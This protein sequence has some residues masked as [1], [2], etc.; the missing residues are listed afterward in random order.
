VV[1]DDVTMGI[2]EVVR[3]ADLATSAPR[4]A[5]LARLLGAEASLADARDPYPSDP[6][7]RLTSREER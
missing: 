5:L 3:G 7:R 2:T 4:Q 1:V 6:G